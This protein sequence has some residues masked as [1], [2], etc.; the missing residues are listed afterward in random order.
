[1]GRSG[2]GVSPLLC[3][4]PTPSSTPGWGV[5]ATPGSPLFSFEYSDRF[6]DANSKCFC[7]SAVA[8]ICPAP[9]GDCAQ[10][11]AYIVGHANAAAMDKH[12]DQR[13]YIE[14]Q[15]HRREQDDRSERPIKENDY[16]ARKLGRKD[17][18]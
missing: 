17:R 13:P 16:G 10:P 18:P 15:L 7:C 2:H 6:I 9:G 12:C 3:V 14:Q 4:M 8:P 11:V 1:M 5:A